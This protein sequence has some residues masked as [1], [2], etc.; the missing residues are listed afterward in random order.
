MGTLPLMLPLRSSCIVWLLVFFSLATSFKA[1]AKW[2]DPSVVYT[3]NRFA[4]I[5]EK[6]GP[7]LSSASE[8]KPDDAEAP[9]LERNSL[10]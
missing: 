1:F 7:V 3:Y 9:E 8:L 10:L 2:D 4:E 6:C 5:Q